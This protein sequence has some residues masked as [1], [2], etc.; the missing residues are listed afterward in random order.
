MLG[1]KQDILGRYSDAI[2]LGKGI[3]IAFVVAAH[4]T[5]SGKTQETM[6]DVGMFYVMPFFVFVSG[7][8]YACG[9]PVQNI[10]EYGE[11]LKKKVLRIL[12]PYIGIPLLLLVPKY[13]AGL[14]IELHNPVK[15]NMLVYFAVDPLKTFL[16]LF[17]FL[18][19]LMEIY[20]LF[21]LISKLIRNDF[22][23]LAV[24]LGLA[25]LPW[26]SFLVLNRLFYNLPFFALGYVAVNHGWL[27][28][29][30]KLWKFIIPLF[31]AMLISTWLHHFDLF[32]AVSKSYFLAT[33]IIGSIGL[34][35]IGYFLS[36]HM[37]RA[38]ALVKTIGIYSMIIYVL[39]L[40]MMGPARIFFSRVLST[41]SV[42]FLAAAVFTVALGV[43]LPMI[44]EKYIIRKSRVLTVIILGARPD[45]VEKPARFHPSR[46][47][48]H[49]EAEATGS[50]IDISG[51]KS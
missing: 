32:D 20:S 50:A 16:P 43:F 6:Y 31:V 2:Y 12:V 36:F 37:N 19:V 14:F 47:G 8:L 22:A 35:L 25:V 9:G 38:V 23:L 29:P 46:K 30:E 42:L 11:L 3:G 24:L 33:G 26:P 15:I 7:F 13:I 49:H 44:A 45:K 27:R 5:L 4:Y 28:Q 51:V 41:D 21:P 18:Y 17:W 48:C 10:S 39:H 40:P 1:D 34:L